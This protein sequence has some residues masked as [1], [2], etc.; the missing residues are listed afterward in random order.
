MPRFRMYFPA[1]RGFRCR[2]ILTGRST[3][4]E[5]RRGHHLSSCWQPA[6][7]PQVTLWVPE[8]P[9]ALNPVPDA[10]AMLEPDPKVRAERGQLPFRS[11]TAAVTKV[12]AEQLAVPAE[13]S[14]GA[15]G[16]QG[17]VRTAEVPVALFRPKMANSWSLPHSRAVFPTRFPVR[18]AVMVAHP[19]EP[20]QGP[21]K[22]LRAMSAQRRPLGPVRGSPCPRPQGPGVCASE[23]RMPPP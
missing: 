4:R 16:L 1:R 6:A 19:D 3:L 21:C 15:E 9:A 8:V 22:V 13:F 17:P 10:Q 5:Y 23:R 20:E 11:A 18:A 14:R 12:W 2:I 7:A